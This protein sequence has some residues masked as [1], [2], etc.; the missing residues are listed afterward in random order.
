MT[1]VQCPPRVN[2]RIHVFFSATSN[3][4]CSTM[5]NRIQAALADLDSQAVVNYAATARR[6]NIERTTLA[7]RHQRKPTSRS[8]ANSKYRQRLTNVQEKTLLD[9]L[10]SLKKRNILLTSQIVQNLAK[11]ARWQ[12]CWQ[13]SEQVNLY[14]ASLKTDYLFI[15]GVLLTN[16][17]FLPNLYIFS[18]T[19][20]LLYCDFA[21]V[22]QNFFSTF[23][24]AYKYYREIQSYYQIYLQLG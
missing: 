4:H 20:I 6:W 12:S 2:A 9:Y 11:G 5:E 7:R 1:A 16:L 19:F 13:E 23:V 14:Q 15:F 8:D 24:A 18:E 10:D 22:I 17:A 21:A 3:Y